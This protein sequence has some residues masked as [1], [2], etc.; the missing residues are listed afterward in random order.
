MEY[1]KH[2]S[3]IVKIKGYVTNKYGTCLCNSAKWVVLW[4]FLVI[5]DLSL[6]FDLF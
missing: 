3:N 4:D 6:S 5:L 2:H 1:E